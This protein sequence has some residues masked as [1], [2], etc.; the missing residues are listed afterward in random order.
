M[1]STE[2]LHIAAGGTAEDIVF[3]VCTTVAAGIYALTVGISEA[4]SFCYKVFKVA[5]QV[6]AIILYMI[7]QAVLFTLSI[8]R[9]AVLATMYI[10]CLLYHDYSRDAREQHRALV[11]AGQKGLNASRRMSYRFT[12]IAQTFYVL[13][14]DLGK[15]NSTFQLCSKF[16]LYVRLLD[17]LAMRLTRRILI[18]DFDEQLGIAPPSREKK[19]QKRD[20]KQRAEKEVSKTQAIAE[21]P[22]ETETQAATHAAPGT[23]AATPRCAWNT[24]SNTTLAPGTQA[25]THAAPGTQAATH[26]APGT[27]AAT[28]AAPGT[29]AATHGCAWNTSSNTPLRLEHKQ[30]HTL[31]LEHKQQHRRCAWNTREYRKSLM[32]FS[33]IGIQ[34]DKEETQSVKKA[35]DAGVCSACEAAKN[36]YQK[37]Y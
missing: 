29:Q 37:C 7:P 5:L 24:S 33:T 14:D 15:H 18:G 32:T 12:Y 10:S 4:S 13:Q 31:R 28:H 35:S 20:A 27:Q 3:G 34:T 16:R 1:N 9:M 25:A 2:R 23:Q 22:A 11:T 8:P 36:K 19:R 26:A 21:A 6:A 17:S 30:Q